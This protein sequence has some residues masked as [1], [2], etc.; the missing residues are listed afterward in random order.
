MVAAAA[1][2]VTSRPRI[3]R[4]QARRGTR[5]RLEPI[6]AWSQSDH[7]KTR[8][9][10]VRGHL[11]SSNDFGTHTA[12]P[13]I[14]QRGEC[15]SGPTARRCRA[16]RRRRH[17]SPAVAST[18]QRT[19]A[20]VYCCSTPSTAARARQTRQLVALCSPMGRRRPDCGATWSTV[21]SER[22]R[23]APARVCG[24][25]TSRT[26]RVRGERI[27]GGNVWVGGGGRER[28]ARVP[29]DTQ[30]R[31]RRPLN[32]EQG[33]HPKSATWFPRVVCHLARTRA[34]DQSAL[35]AHHAG[36]QSRQCPAD[37]GARAPYAYTPS[38]A[39][40]TLRLG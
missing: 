26:H 4:W 34:V 20:D 1:A 8:T 36:S 32:L 15:E 25:S 5:T 2:V 13:A 38:A 21:P 10:H 16:R 24:R 7:R 18:R 27:G 12:P 22:A 19:R 40:H 23:H 37:S 31:Q 30:P 35:C 14:T 17:K 11:Q 3:D 29:A 33:R 9:P 6:T 28:L 39:A